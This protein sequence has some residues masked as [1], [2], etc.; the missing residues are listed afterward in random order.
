MTET[1]YSD[2]GI[3]VVDDTKESL[4]LLTELL[5]KAGYRV[6]AAT[7]GAMAL[8]SVMV[9]EPDLILLDILMPEMDGYAVC[10]RLKNSPKTRDIPV[11]FISGMN[12][13]MDKVKAF[14]VGG[15]D[16][17]EKPFQA[18]EVIARVNTHLNIQHL[19]TKLKQQNI[20]LQQAA[21][22]LEQRVEERT[23]ELHVS[24]ERYRLITASARDAII[25][26][27]DRGT[28][29]SWNSGAQSLFGWSELQMV[30]EN[31]GRIIPPNHLQPDEPI[32]F[33]R[34]SFNGSTVTDR[35]TIEGLGLH[36]DGRIIPLEL[37]FASWTS[38]NRLYWTSIIRDISER[39]LQEELKV[40]AARQ[41]EQLQR[42]ESL[43]TMAAAIAHR[44]NNSM[45]AI[46]GNLQLMYK[47]MPLGS[48]DKGRLANA[49]KAANEAAKVGT[50]M[51]GYLGQRRQNLQSVNLIDIARDAL[52]ELQDTM[53]GG[54]T[55]KLHNTDQWL[56]CS[57]DPAQI[58]E[59]MS[60]LV[61][62]SLESPGD[63]ALYIEVDFGRQHCLIESFPM[64]FR[65]NNQQDGQ[66]CYCTIT[67]NGQGIAPENLQRVFEPFYSTKFV[68]RGFGLAQAAGIINAHQGAITVESSPGRGATFTVFL[69]ETEAAPTT[70]LQPA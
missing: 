60:C 50:M 18:E 55:V 24:E 48:K 65:R 40:E 16:Y 15:V 5:A 38:D 46:L 41:Q 32:G 58:K 17:I 47:L 31:L 27:D 62:N 52:A 28:I 13:P 23:R 30:G 67:D 45:M 14:G 8:R 43:K 42:Y 6:R 20:K 33:H 22:A 57:L 12:E 29:T 68:G 21:V 61:T 69:P 36:R 51:L 53:P 37:S 1:M 3:L 59:V 35:Q 4:K 64:V 19:Q 39:Q 2:G 70:I 7:D 63:N 34:F 66:Y 9:K 10:R 11:I 26:I 56:P 25:S 49:L 44:F 54:I